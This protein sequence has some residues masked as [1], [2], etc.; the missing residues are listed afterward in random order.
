MSNNNLHDIRLA[1]IACNEAY[2]ESLGISQ[3]K[4]SKKHLTK[5]TKIRKSKRKLKINYNQT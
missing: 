2:L 4:P 1:N 5:K 3:V